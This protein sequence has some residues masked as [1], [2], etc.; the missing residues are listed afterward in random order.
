M[1]RAVYLVETSVW[2]LA[3]VHDQ[4]MDVD[5]QP[6]YSEHDDNHHQRPT[7]FAF[8]VDAATS[9]AS[10]RHCHVTAAGQR[11]RR[12]RRRNG[13]LVMHDVTQ[14]T[15]REDDDDRQ[16]NE[17]GKREESSVE[18][19]GGQVTGDG[20][21]RCPGR[22]IHDGAVLGQDRSVDGQHQN[23]D[24]DDHRDDPAGRAVAGRARRVDDRHVANDGDED[25]R[26]DGDVG[27]DVDQ[28]VHQSTRRVAERPPVGRE[29]VRSRR[30]DDDDERQ[31][32]D[33]QIQQQEIGHGSHTLFGRDDVDD[34]AVADDTEDCNYAVQKWHGD[35]VQNESEI[36]IG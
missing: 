13:R 3:E 4:Q 31:V 32:G 24:G 7:C 16:R 34:E 11:C 6:E 15:D 19:L 14:D 5:G 35:F 8:L 18:L 23:P 25:Q 10:S 26:V 9:L 2:D 22:L 29:H 17:V 33:G 1:C 30:R 36:V 20:T 28:V 27:G 21:A 12:Q